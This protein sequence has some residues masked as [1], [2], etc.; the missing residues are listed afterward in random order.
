MLQ[1]CEAAAPLGDVGR[2]GRCNA[3]ERSSQ[4]NAMTTT[5][6][7]ARSAAKASGRGVDRRLYRAATEYMTTIDG[8][9]DPSIGPGEYDVYSAS[10]AMYRVRPS[11]KECDCPDKAHRLGDDGLCKHLYR[12]IL[13]DG[14]MP[15]PAGI[16]RDEIDP[17]LGE[18]V[19]GPI[20]ALE[21]GR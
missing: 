7:Y 21:A 4:W 11:A 12:A 19:D 16:P 5:N 17:A 1:Q 20:F 3:R 14:Q 13:A 6:Q 10:G 9:I 15:V 2:P 18:H 8:R